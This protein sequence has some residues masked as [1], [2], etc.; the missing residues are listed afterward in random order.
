MHHQVVNMVELGVPMGI[1]PQLHMEVLLVQQELPMAVMEP[2]VMEGN[3]GMDQVVPLVGTMEVTGDN[4]MED[5][6][7]IMLLQVMSLLVLIQRRTS[8]SRLLTRT[9]VVSST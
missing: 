8:G 1:S 7:D 6:A 2:Q 5:L 9:E 3:M 4:P